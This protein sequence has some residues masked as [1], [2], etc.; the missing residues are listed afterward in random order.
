MKSRTSLLR[1][2][3]EYETR[4]GEVSTREIEPEYIHTSTTLQ[5]GLVTLLRAVDLADGRPRDFAMKRIHRWTE[6]PR[7]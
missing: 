7:R 4:N 1:V 3:I 2:F 5:D 6:G